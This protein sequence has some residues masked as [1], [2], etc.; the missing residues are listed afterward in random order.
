MLFLIFC[1]Q[2]PVIDDVKTFISITEAVV[3]LHN[4]FINETCYIYSLPRIFL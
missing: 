4:F 2:K 3:S 1:L